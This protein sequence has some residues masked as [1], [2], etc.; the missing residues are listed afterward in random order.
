MNLLRVESSP[1]KGNSRAPSSSDFQKGVTPVPKAKNETCTLNKRLK[2]EQRKSCPP[3]DDPTEC[4]IDDSTVTICCSCFNLCCP[5]GEDEE[6]A[7][8]DDLMKSGSSSTVI[9]FPGDPIP[10]KPS[11]TNKMN[12]NSS[13]DMSG[14]EEEDKLNGNTSTTQSSEDR[15]RDQSSTKTRVGKMTTKRLAVSKATVSKK[16]P[17]NSEDENEYDQDTN[18]DTSTTEMKNMKDVVSGA[19]EHLT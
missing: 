12:K 10:G 11:D 18:T 4:P 2:D 9:V 3:E 1:V 19:G 5:L 7:M 14:S 13:Q 17:M 8:E 15:S 6:K 16:D